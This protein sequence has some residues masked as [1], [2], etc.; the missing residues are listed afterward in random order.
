[1]VLTGYVLCCPSLHLAQLAHLSAAFIRHIFLSLH[2]QGKWFFKQHD[3]VKTLLKW[4]GNS[5]VLWCL[6]CV[7]WCIVVM[8]KVWMLRGTDGLG[9]AETSGQWGREQLAKCSRS[10]VSSNTIKHGSGWWWWWRVFCFPVYHFNF[11]SS[12][13][14]KLFKVMSLMTSKNT[15]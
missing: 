13:R 15:P 4:T 12:T 2:H 7:H 3:S 9:R 6:P 8:Y 14:K 10:N 1:M 5:S 11:R